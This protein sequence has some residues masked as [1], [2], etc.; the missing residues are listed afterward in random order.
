M[1]EFG[2]TADGSDDGTF[3]PF[4]DILFNALLGLAVMVFMAFAL[5]NPEAKTG[6][7]DVKAEFIVTVQWP[8]SN[9]D[10]VDTYVE[11]PLGNLV[12]YHSRESGFLVLDRDDRGNYRDTITVNGKQIQNPLNQETV[13]I[14]KIIPGE[15]IVNVSHYIANTTE[16]LP[17]RVKVEKVNPRLTV[18]YYGT[19]TM[20]HKGQEVTAVRFSVDAEGNV[21][22]VNTRPKSLIQ[23]VRKPSA[24]NAPR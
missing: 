3:V 1:D 20:D 6:V 15:Y 16:P 10:D 12:W 23:A 14:R 18:V 11:D 22:D 8:D 5:I 4:T 21:S 17:V 7:V 24:G 13:T 9:P 19:I 2:L